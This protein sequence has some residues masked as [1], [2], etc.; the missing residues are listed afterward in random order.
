MD[1]IRGLPKAH[2]YD[3]LLV[4]VDRLSTYANFIPLA[5]P[6]TAKDVATAFIK[7]VVRLH[8]FLATIV[9]NMDHVFLSSFWIELFKFFGTKKRLSDRNHK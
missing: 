2:R 6:Y 1:F 5:Y 9:S 3:T 4:V 7:E 8:R